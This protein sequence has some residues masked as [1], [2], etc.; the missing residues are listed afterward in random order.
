MRSI[1]S[2]H[3]F[4]TRTDPQERRS[5][6]RAITIGLALATLG[7]LV[8]GLGIS[9]EWQP[10]PPTEQHAADGVGPAVFPPHALT[11]P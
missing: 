7:L 4:A 5:L 10:A 8:T 1:A 6:H 9:A 3:P 11:V 2:P